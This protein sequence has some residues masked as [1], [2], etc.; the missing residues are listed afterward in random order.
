MTPDPATAA[1]AA[2][3]EG[4]TTTARRQAILAA[5]IAFDKAEAATG[6]MRRELIEEGERWLELVSQFQQKADKRKISSTM[7]SE[8][9]RDPSETEEASPDSE[10]E[11]RERPDERL[12]DIAGLEDAKQAIQEMILLPLAKPEWA[13]ALNLSAGGGVLLYGPPGNGKT[14]LGRAIAGELDVPFFYA[15]GAQIRSKWHGESEQR[16]RQLMKAVKASKQAVLFLDEIDGLLPRRSGKSVVDN[17][18]VTQF[19]AELGGFEKSDSAILILGATN[20]PWEIDDAVYRTGRFDVKIYVGLPD[21]EAR[22]RILEL[23]LDLADTK[24]E[25]N[26]LDWAERL[27]GYCGSD[28]AGIVN[29]AKRSAL[30]RAVAEDSPPQVL[31]EDFVSTFAQVSPS[32]GPQLLKRYMKFQNDRVLG[33]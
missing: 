1:Y 16:L 24:V 20:C 15:S 31:N 5:K 33:A 6:K 7:P 21:L 26:L 8:K 3:Q 9:K 30:S 28:I 29:A 19:L 22:R 14:L 18:I 32:A 11:I 27:D 23:E 17:R 4:D 2:L 25:P 13:A 10:W 12:S